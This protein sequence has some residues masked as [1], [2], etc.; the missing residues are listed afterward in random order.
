MRDASAR[1]GAPRGGDERTGVLG[2]GVLSKARMA[3]PSHRWA[4]HNDAAPSPTGWAPEG[5]G[6]A[7]EEHGWSGAA[8][9]LTADDEQSAVADFNLHVMALLLEKG[10][11]RLPKRQA[12]AEELV[13]RVCL[14]WLYYDEAWSLAK[15]RDH[16]RACIMA[17]LGRRALAPHRAMKL[18]ATL[19]VLHTHAVLTARLEAP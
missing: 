8:D 9:A 13:R 11:W 17:E 6:W 10:P 3:L 19:E 12:E 1:A 16:R 18:R 4:Q 2:G 7:P 14:R 15:L 5:H